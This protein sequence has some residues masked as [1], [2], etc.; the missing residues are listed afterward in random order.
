MSVLTQ[1]HPVPQEQT[2]VRVCG[3]TIL[4]LATCFCLTTLYLL[5]YVQGF[6]FFDNDYDWINQARAT[7]WLA[8]CYD[9]L[10]PIPE[11]WGFQFRPGQVFVTKTLLAVFGEHAPVFYIFKCLS[12]GAVA[13][14][15]AGFLR[16]AGEHWKTAVVAAAIFGLSTATLAS[17]MWVSDF[18]LVA[19]I[20]TLAAMGAFWFAH[21]RDRGHTAW[22]HT[23]LRHALVALL[24]ILA[25]RTKGSAKILP[26]VLM[27]YLAIWRRDQFWK[28]LPA[29][30]CVGLT[31]V[32]LLTLLENPIPPFAPFSEDL[33]Q[34]W[35][36]KPANLGTLGILLIG[37]AHLLYGTQD[38]LVAYS[39]LANLFPWLLWPAILA[40][41]VWI[42][43]NDRRIRPLTGFLGIWLF[44]ALV[45]YSAYPR[46]PHGFM[47][48]YVV[49]ALVPAS[50]LVALAIS[51]LA[52]HVRPTRRKT[53]A[54]VVGLVLLGHGVAQS[55]SNRYQRETLGQAIVAYDRARTAI[56]SEIRD[57]DVVILGFEYGYNRERVDTNRYHDGPYKT[58]NVLQAKPLYI[59]VR[60]EQDVDRPRYDDGI[61]EIQSDVAF[62]KPAEGQLKVGI[63]PVAMYD[64]LTNSIYDRLFYRS[65]LSFV[66]LLYQVTYEP[67][68][69]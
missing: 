8:G 2:A 18:E 3:E 31:I 69:S 66:G 53:A 49:V 13:T 23:V 24:L 56:A 45:A 32:P 48:R 51:R 14:G 38:G 42:R 26:I 39:L 61:R 65:R 11:D 7:S 68:A 19:Q 57:A 25:H 20:L 52:D 16:L 41:A 17:A 37:N 58:A 59:L 43:S 46:L 22:P 4:V 9:L 28:W 1:T 10:R 63:R 15:I 29:M 67:M 62:E 35:M 40:I 60:S 44:A 36:W 54:L 30:G 64:G 50:I 5:F 55:E 27:A 6:R 33:S 47:A 34:G 12:A 21:E